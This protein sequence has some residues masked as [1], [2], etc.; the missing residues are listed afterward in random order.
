MLLHA[1][2]YNTNINAEST[3]FLNKVIKYSKEKHINKNF[4]NV[5]TDA[6]LNSFNFPWNLNFYLILYLMFLENEIKLT[7]LYLT[8]RSV[9]NAFC[10][11]FS[12]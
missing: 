6:A 7:Y 8:L 10:L 1:F 4:L 9:D 12:N 11:A 2:T 3:L 5:R